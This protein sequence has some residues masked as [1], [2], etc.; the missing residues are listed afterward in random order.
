MDADYLRKIVQRYFCKLYQLNSVDDRLFG[1]FITQF[2]PNDG[3]MI[4]FGN[5]NAINLTISEIYGDG[6][7]DTTVYLYFV[8][9][10]DG[11][12]GLWAG[13]KQFGYDFLIAKFDVSAFREGDERIANKK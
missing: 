12:I 11:Q 5:S 7:T 13:L 2:M 8:E 4:G 9:A 6:K 3:K 10:K 1:V